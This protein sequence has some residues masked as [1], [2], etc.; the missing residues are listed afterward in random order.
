MNVVIIFKINS[1]PK[2]CKAFKKSFTNTKDNLIHQI[3]DSEMLEAQTIYSQLRHT[4]IH[5]RIFNISNSF[6]RFVQL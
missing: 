4:T 2:R 6:I 1:L 3:F 5:N